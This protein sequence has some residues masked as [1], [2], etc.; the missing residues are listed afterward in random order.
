MLA[1]RRP[2]RAQEGA[3]SLLAAPR[4]RPSR[5]RAA[6]A[7]PAVTLVCKRPTACGRSSTLTTARLTTKAA[8]ASATKRGPR[9]KVKFKFLNGRPPETAY[10][11]F[12]QIT[13]ARGQAWP[14]TRRTWTAGPRT[15]CLSTTGRSKTSSKSSTK[16]ISISLL[17]E[18]T[19]RLSLSPASRTSP[20][21][22]SRASRVTPR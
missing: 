8:A 14:R 16:K 18:A 1:S 15:G 22:P 19:L 13:S 21:A 10:N 12:L 17:T 3:T 9:L 4:P 6:G 2:K 11:L 20:R 7:R 5:G